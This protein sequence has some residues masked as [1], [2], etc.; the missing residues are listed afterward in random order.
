MKVKFPL[1]AAVLLL[2]VSAMA[3]VPAMAQDSG[4]PG[5]PGNVFFWAQTQPPGPVTA[6]HIK[7]AHVAEEGNVMFRTSRMI[8]PW[9]KNSEIANQIH[10]TD[11][12]K[13]DIDQSFYQYRLQLIDATAATEKLDMQLD[14][15]MNADDLQEGQI[16]QT[17]DKLVQARGQLTKIYA[18]MLISIR[19]VL[20]PEQWKSLQNLQA[21]RGPMPMMNPMEPGGLG[22]G[23]GFGMGMPPAA[24]GVIIQRH[25]ERAP[26]PAFAGRLLHRNRRHLLNRN[27]SLVASVPGR[28]EFAPAGHFSFR[29]AIH[30]AG[31]TNRMALVCDS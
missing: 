11:Q 19:K 25:L 4:Y 2:A 13:K 17:L 9:W 7:G 12:Q 22:M 27:F 8:G 30:R 3:Q 6:G 20:Q 29:N 24:G 26:M 23:M 28:L 18:G 15:L 10:L 16:N 1:A 31:E 5:E 14:Q 21:E